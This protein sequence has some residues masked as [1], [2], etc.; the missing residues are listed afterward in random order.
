MNHRA[1]MYS[2]AVDGFLLSLRSNGYS[3][4]TI[5]IYKWGLS[6]LPD[7][8]LAS[9]RKED[10]QEVF[11]SLYNSN[12][13]MASIENIWIATRSFWNWAEKEFSIQR[14]DNDISKPDVPDPDIVPYAQSEI[15]RLLAA[16]DYTSKSNTH[17]RT[18]Y[19]M[20]RPTA[21]RDKTIILVLLDTG[22]RVGELCRLK[23]GDINIQTGEIQIHPFGRGIK[24]KPRTVYISSS[25]KSFA[26]KYTVGQEYRPG[27]PLFI[28]SAGNAFNRKSARL[29]LSRIGKRAGVNNT[30][31]HR[32]R[33][34]FA[35]EYLRNGGDIYTLQRLLG[36]SSWKMVRRYLDIAQSDCEN[37]HRRASPV[38]NWKL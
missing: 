5:Q 25:T 33:H 27:D 6:K 21:V 37:A 26:W 1:L 10:L 18:S 7:K 31:P 19:R 24:S 8:Q 34:T 22:I 4:S 28:T 23:H 29:L 20:R 38:E 14:P 16:C 3:N 2:Q 9:I 35:I 12:L 30:H 32:F 11:T 13:S 17:G 15:K 36:L